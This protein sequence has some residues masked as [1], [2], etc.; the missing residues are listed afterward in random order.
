MEPKANSEVL[1]GAL[2]PNNIKFNIV[3]GIESVKLF[4]EIAELDRR[5]WTNS[6]DA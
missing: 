4:A 3:Q 1:C 5:A 2:K 6:D